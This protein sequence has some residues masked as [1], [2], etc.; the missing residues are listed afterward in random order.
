MT[1]L[2]AINLLLKHFPVLLTRVD[3]Q[4]DMMTAPPYFAYGLL[5]TEV[6][7]RAADEE[8]V[9]DVCKFLDFMAGSGDPILEEVL[10]VSV[11]ERIADEPGVVSSLRHCLGKATLAQ[12]D[13]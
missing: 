6:I 7:T 3:S 10:V 4:D 1:S 9:R 12:L 11:L 13:R 5:A 8:F 2:N